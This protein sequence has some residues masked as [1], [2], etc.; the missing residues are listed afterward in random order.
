MTMLHV[1]TPM[2]CLV[3]SAL[4]A[5]GI[6]PAASAQRGREIPLPDTVGANFSI[7]DTA[8]KAGAPGDYD[9]LIGLWHFRF[10]IRKRDGT[11]I[12]AFTGHWTFEKKPGGLLIED[13]WRPDEP[14][15]A[16]GLSLYTY[17]LFDPKRKLWQMIGAESSGGTFSPGL[18]WSDATHR[19]AIQR[20]ETTITRIRYLAIEPNKFLWRAD[21][22]SDGGKTWLLDAMTMDASRIGK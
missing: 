9:A 6:A 3:V 12:P 15:S 2:R 19:Y 11:F 17:R 22:S 16:M 7:A 5:L 20:D 18:T 13:R 21:R 14:D 4:V 8:T 1:M 10:Q